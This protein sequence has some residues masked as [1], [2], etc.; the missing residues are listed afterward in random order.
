MSPE[1]VRDQADA[2]FY[3]VD[4]GAALVKIEAIGHKLG[5]R[6]YVRGEEFQL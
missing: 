4:Q 1:H 2:V 3:D 6:L 5:N